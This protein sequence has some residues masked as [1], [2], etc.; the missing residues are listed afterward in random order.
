M[1]VSMS[2]LLPFKEAS[3]SADLELK[4]SRKKATPYPSLPLT[5]LVQDRGHIV[6]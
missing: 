3:E 1:A 2:E 6:C 5:A 4:K